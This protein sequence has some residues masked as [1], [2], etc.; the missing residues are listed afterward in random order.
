MSVGG[1]MR[2]EETKPHAHL[3]GFTSHASPSRVPRFACILPPAGFINVRFWC[4]LAGTGEQFKKSN[5]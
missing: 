3:P 4:N 2:D 1:E 5:L